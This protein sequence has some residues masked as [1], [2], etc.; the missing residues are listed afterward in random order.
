MAGSL[1]N[2]CC[3]VVARG[4]STQTGTYKS[5]AEAILMVNS[6]PTQ[7]PENG[8]PMF[9][10]DEAALQLTRSGATWGQSA[11]GQPLVVTYAFRGTAPATMPS[12]TAGFQ[13]FTIAQIEAAEASLQAWSQVANIQFVRVGEGTAGPLAFSNSAAILFANYTTGED[14]AAAFAFTPQTGDQSSNS[15]QGDIWVNISQ[16]ENQNSDSGQLWLADPDA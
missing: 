6:S 5:E 13:R 11:V 14:G 9:S 12:D 16:V 2:S 7:F 15:L 3:H 10:W 1:P 8:K 4:L